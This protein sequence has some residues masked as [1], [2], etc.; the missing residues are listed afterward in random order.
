MG[1][2]A[3]LGPLVAGFII[4]ADVAGLSWRPVFLINI[5]LGAV[6][7]VAAVKLLPV[8]E[9]VSDVP[10]DGLGAGLLVPACSA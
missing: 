8:D 10:I 7:L 6:G 4:D 1:G 5:V 2:S 9:P 3:V